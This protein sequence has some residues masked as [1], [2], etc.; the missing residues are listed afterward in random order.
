M[1]AEQW[2]VLRD[3]MLLAVVLPSSIVGVGAW[4]IARRNR[5]WPK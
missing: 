1:T 5:R 3:V 2:L 4:W